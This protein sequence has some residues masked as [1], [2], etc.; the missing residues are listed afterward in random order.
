MCSYLAPKIGVIYF[1]L[2]GII[3]CLAGYRFAFILVMFFISSSML[4][5]LNPH[6]K[7]K[8][9]ESFKEGGQ[10]DFEQVVRSPLLVAP[11][12]QSFV[13]SCSLAGQ[14]ANGALGTVLC[15]LWLWFVG[16]GDQNI[17]FAQWPIPSFLLATFLG[18]II[19]EHSF[20]HSFILCYILSINSFMCLFRHYA[21]C[22][23][24]TW[25]SEVGVLS[26]SNPI[27]IT[28]WKKVSSLSSLSS[29]FSFSFSLSG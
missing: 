21:C 8:I 5:K 28:T 7:R 2:Q 24:D 15:L 13:L 27:L 23:G 17:D 10:R 14:F 29:F 6:K 11:I 3:T 25:A 18:Y 20:I 16:P 22:N 9:D 12:I 19:H 1:L 26:S 4:S